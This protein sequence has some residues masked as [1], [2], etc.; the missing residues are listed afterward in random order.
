MY[1]EVVK[2]FYQEVTKD[3]IFNNPFVLSIDL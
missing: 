3:F 2:Y 1:K